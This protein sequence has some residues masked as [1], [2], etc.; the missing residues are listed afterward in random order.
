MVHQGEDGLMAEDE[1][2][3]AAVRRMRRY[4][5]LDREGSDRFEVPL[6]EMWVRARAVPTKA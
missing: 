4:R 2:L 3:A 5:V 6:M 1:V